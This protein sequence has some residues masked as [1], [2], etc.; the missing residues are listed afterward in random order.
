MGSRFSTRVTALWQDEEADGLAANVVVVF[1]DAVKVESRAPESFPPLSQA[2]SILQ[3][4][5]LQS[6]QFHEFDHSSV[7]PQRPTSDEQR[8]IERL[9]RKGGQNM[10]NGSNFHILIYSTRDS[11]GGSTVYGVG[12]GTNAQTRRKA[13]RIALGVAY[14]KWDAAG[15]QISDEFFPEELR[16]FVAYCR[17]FNA[18]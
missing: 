9:R 3:G 14:A 18:G 1:C 12:I 10:Q 5:W 7:T 8:I 17:Q 15:Q 11:D 13:G 4:L 2:G 16:E 6:G